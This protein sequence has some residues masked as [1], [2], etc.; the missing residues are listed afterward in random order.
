MIKRKTPRVLVLGYPYFVSRLLEL[1]K[2]SGLEMHALPKGWWQRLI[3]LIRCNLI[4]QIGGDLRPNRF[5]RLAF[6]LG[7]KQIIHW[8]GSDI[9]AMKKLAAQGFKFSP[10]FTKKAVHWVE[11]NWIAKE[12]TELGIIGNVVPLTPAAFPKKAPDLP[13]KFVVLTYLP[14]EKSAFYGEAQIIALAEEFPEIVFLA[15]AASTTETN[16]KWPANLMA[17]GWVNDMARIYQEI[18][19]L[20]RLPE[21]DGLSFMVLEALANGRHVIWNYAFDG[22]R[23][24]SGYQQT[25]QI[26]KDLLRDYERGELKLN[27]AGREF[28]KKYYSQAVVWEQISR[29]FFEVLKK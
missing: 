18:T 9:I 16:P 8:V 15:A 13:E 3:S 7:K 14:P 10:H 2:D 12:L 23:Q 5:H 24:T 1:G 20:I 19:V 22:V 27:E 6:L 29:G 11:V 4:Y 28:V 25:V 17:V 26:L 21:H